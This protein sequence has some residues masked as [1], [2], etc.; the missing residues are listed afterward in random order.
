MR[1]PCGCAAA[2]A[3][4]V[5]A[6]TGRPCRTGHAGRNPPALGGLGPVLPRTVRVTLHRMGSTP[7]RY[8]NPAQATFEW[9][10]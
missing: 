5:R 8:R 2:L 6:R 10:E 1:R 9:T 3:P 4:L 7:N